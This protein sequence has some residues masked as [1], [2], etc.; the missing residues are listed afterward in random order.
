MNLKLLFGIAGFALITSTT[1]PQSNKPV[2]IVE[3]VDAAMNVHGFIPKP[4]FH[5][6]EKLFTW[7][8]CPEIAQVP[9]K[10][11]MLILHVEVGSAAGDFTIADLAMNIDGNVTTLANLEWTPS[12]DSPSILNGAVPHKTLIPITFATL[13]DMASSQSLYFIFSEPGTTYRMDLHLEKKDLATFQAICQAIK[14]KYSSLTADTEQ[15]IT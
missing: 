1:Y 15:P 11:T 8:I 5:K 6:R 2:Q 10:A 9:N 3:H 13:S 4:C 12:T 7:D 14:D